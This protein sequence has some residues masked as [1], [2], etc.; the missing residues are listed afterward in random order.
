MHIKKHS[1][2]STSQVPDFNS[3]KII[4]PLPGHQV[5]LKRNNTRRY[6]KTI[7][8]TLDIHGNRLIYGDFAAFICED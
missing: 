7:L 2:N 1:R 5:Y 3:C 6:I 4:V 8:G